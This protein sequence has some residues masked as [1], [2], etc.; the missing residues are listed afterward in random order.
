M[1]DDTFSV[2]PL[3][4]YAAAAAAEICPIHVFGKYLSMDPTVGYALLGAFDEP[5][6]VCHLS[7]TM[8]RF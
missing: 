5:F 7:S 4:S 1:H 8:V 3:E 6:P 2:H